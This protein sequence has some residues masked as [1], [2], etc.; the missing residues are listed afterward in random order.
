ARR[1]AVRAPPFWTGRGLLSSLLLPP[2]LLYDLGGWLRWRLV[3]GRPAGVPVICVGNLVAGGAGKTPTVLALA[4]LLQARGLAVHALSRGYGGR[5][6]GPLRVEPARH[7]FREVGDE[8]LLLA[9]ACP[10]WV[11]RDRLAGARAAV[12]A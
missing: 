12:A 2:A 8:P 1:L 9:R 3:R 11:A 6:R 5:A 7:D 10:T 4:E